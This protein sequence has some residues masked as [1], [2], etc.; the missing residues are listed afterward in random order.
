MNSI[1]IPILLM[2][3]PKLKENKELALDQFS[4]VQSL[5][6]IWLFVTPW[7]AARQASLSVTNSQSLSH[8]SKW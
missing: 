8:H 4:S 3:K 5:S 2:R 7:T 1:I 6:H